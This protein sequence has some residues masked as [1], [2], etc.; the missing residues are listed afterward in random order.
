MLKNKAI[1]I[2][3]IFELKTKTG[4]FYLHF[5]QSRNKDDGDLVRVL[6]TAYKKRPKDLSKLVLDK[7]IFVAAILIKPSLRHKLIEK[8]GNVKMLFEWPRYMRTPIIVQSKFYG[9][10]VVDTQTLQREYVYKLN[11]KQKKLSM[12]GIVMIQYLQQK[13][14]EGW[15]L[16]NWQ[17]SIEKKFGNPVKPRKGEFWF[18]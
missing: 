16:E 13:L 2:G 4:Y 18:Y 11:S 7:E 17:S 14:E 15:N 8:V 6:S 9:W 12:F 5:V 3:D 1:E 10:H